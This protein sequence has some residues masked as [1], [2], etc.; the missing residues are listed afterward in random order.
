[1]LKIGFCLFY[2]WGENEDLFKLSRAR[3]YGINSIHNRLSDNLS[4]TSTIYLFISQQAP[5]HLPSWDVAR[6]VA[7]EGGVVEDGALGA[8]N[9]TGVLALVADVEEAAVTGLEVA[10]VVECLAVGV[11]LGL[12][13]AGEA[14][15]ED[16]CVGEEGR[17]SQWERLLTLTSLLRQE[18]MAL[19][20]LS[21]KAS[22]TI[23]RSCY[24]CEAHSI[25]VNSESLPY[26]CQEGKD[27]TTVS[28]TDA[29]A[30][31]SPVSG[32]GPLAGAG[33]LIEDEAGGALAGLRF[34][35]GALVI[36]GAVGGILVLE[37]SVLAGALDAGW[38]GGLWG[39][40]ALMRHRGGTGTLSRGEAMARLIIAVS[41]QREKKRK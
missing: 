29:L 28:L 40:A 13:G 23:K 30:A 39:R 6:V 31:A 1:M 37:V 18:V 20:E 24:L 7:V 41:Q 22:D 2:S 9:L 33:E 38:L 3:L 11:H 27:L 4:I 32:A 5:R 8:S 25:C 14:V 16:L 26:T 35:V 21:G 19:S 36:I 17:T 10:G 12:V 34:A 15:G